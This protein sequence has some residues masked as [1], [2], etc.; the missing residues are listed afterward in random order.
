M[1]VDQTALEKLRSDPGSQGV[2]LPSQ[3]LMTLVKSQAK[4]K[5]VTMSRST[6]PLKIA[7]T[8]PEKNVWGRPMPVKRVRN[9]KRRWYAQTLDRI[10]PPLPEAEWNELRKLASGETRWEGPAR[11]RSQS[12][13]DNAGHDTSR[14]GRVKGLVNSPHDITPRYMR[15]LWTKILAQCPTMKPHAMRKSGWEVSW[16]EV[17]DTQTI[18]LQPSGRRDFA[19]FEGVDE[20]GRLAH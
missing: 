17:Q 5:I 15:R 18:A 16:G 20:R 10:M 6:T 1:P 13:A 8:I 2:P 7:P 14:R 4:R 3:Q 9:L 12:E 19:M 11:R